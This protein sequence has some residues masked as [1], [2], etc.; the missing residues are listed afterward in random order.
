MR[1]P[2]VLSIY[3]KEMR[4]L[5]RDRRTMISMVIVPLLVFPLL[6][7]V[8]T[9]VMVA[10][11]DKSERDLKTMQV[12]VKT[13]IPRFWKRFAKRSCSLWS[14]TTCGPRWNRSR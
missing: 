1:L 4:D 12:G 2:Y 5:I 6:M 8:V 9:R 14:V 13:G 10:M 7:I 11:Q 3:R